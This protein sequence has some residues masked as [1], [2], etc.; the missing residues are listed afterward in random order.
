MSAD[1]SWLQPSN[2]YDLAMW[3]KGRMFSIEHT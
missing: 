2:C 3:G 1:Q